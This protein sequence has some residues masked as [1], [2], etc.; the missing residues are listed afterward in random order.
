MGRGSDSYYR[1]FK[2]DIDPRTLILDRRGSIIF[3]E[4]PGEDSKISS[5]FLIKKIHK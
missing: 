3:L 5:E 1:I 2:Y 4:R